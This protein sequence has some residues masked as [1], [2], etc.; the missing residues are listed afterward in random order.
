MSEWCLTVRLQELVVVMNLSKVS[1]AEGYDLGCPYGGTW[2][3]LF[4][5]DLARYSSSF[6]NVGDGISSLQASNT[7]MH[8]FDYS[9][10]VPLGAYT[11][12][13]LASSQ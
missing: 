12:V 5:S 9:F 10:S 11:T 3:L 2:D 7:P 13:I 1:Y 4:V 6:G 8:G